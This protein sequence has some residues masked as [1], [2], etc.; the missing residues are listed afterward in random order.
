ML[1]SFTCG[2][3]ALVTLTAY[4]CVSVLRRPRA[5]A[6]R[7]RESVGKGFEVSAIAPHV[8]RIRDDHLAEKSSRPHPSPHR[9]RSL[10]AAR[11]FIARL[12]YFRGEKFEH[13]AQRRGA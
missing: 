12:A 5:R 7:Q 8:Q 2:L 3:I 6:A 4:L 1:D 9:A 10:S 13:E 11:R